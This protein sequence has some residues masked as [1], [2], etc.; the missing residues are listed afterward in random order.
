MMNNYKNIYPTFSDHSLLIYCRKIKSEKITRQ[1]V[2]SRKMTNF[3]VDQ[4]R[5]DL[6]QHPQ[7]LP[8]LFDGNVDSTAENL[9]KI[10]QEALDTQSP[11]K[12]YLIT[13]KNRPK[14]N[15]EAREIL[16][17]RDTSHQEYK[18]TGHP[19]DLRNM[20]HLRNLANKKISIENYMNNVKK[21]QQD[22]D[23][24]TQKWKKMKTH[25]GQ[26]KYDT[27]YLIIEGKKPS[28]SSPRKWPMP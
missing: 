10:I 11:V 15:Q 25:T 22:G 2:R 21:F 1:F 8:C 14:I 5:N 18:K 4:Y 17:M 19:N 13:P 23:S 26:S 9:V 12:R 6:F 16:V 24:T 20:K 27:P 7:Y 28:H 3:N